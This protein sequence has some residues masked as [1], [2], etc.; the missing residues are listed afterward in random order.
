MNKGANEGLETEDTVKEALGNDGLLY[1]APA[2]DAPVYETP[3][4][5]APGYDV[6]QGIVIRRRYSGKKTHGKSKIEFVL[7]L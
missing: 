4:Y 7:L 6:F 1:D 3:G 5:D 2:Y